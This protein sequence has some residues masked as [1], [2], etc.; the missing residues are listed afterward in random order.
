VE[1]Q[2]N[3]LIKNGIIP[4]NSLNKLTEWGFIDEKGKFNCSDR[5]TAKMSGTTHM[6]NYL[7]SVGNSVRKD[8]L[9][10][11]KTWT[12]PV[13]QNNPAF[14]WS[15][16]YAEIPQEIKNFAQNILT[17]FDFKYEWVYFNQCGQPPLDI[18]RFQ[19]KQA[20]LQIASPICTGWNEGTMLKP[21]GTCIAGHA[22]MIY[23]ID[24]SI[25]DFDHY[26]PFNKTL[27]LDYTIPYAIKMVV[28]LKEEPVPIPTIF[29]HVF[30][31]DLV[32]GERCPEVVALQKGLK[33]LGF[34]PANILETGYYG[35]ITQK[36][37]KDFQY[38]YNVASSW[39]LAIV[40]GKRV[41]AKTRAKLNELL[42]K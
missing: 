33:I 31:I 39:E 38:F 32:F 42:I 41:G 29:N 37:V 4:V 16:Y 1:T 23:G 12:Y 17:I 20:P 3:F 8:G 30:T 25:K 10:P 13:N 26:E 11:E 36:A 5:F 35:T 2:I 27:S 7:P 19:L 14:E 40:N 34:F 22:T 28:S 6:G 21:C 15:A 24:S 9:V 18:I